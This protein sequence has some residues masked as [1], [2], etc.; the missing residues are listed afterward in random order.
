MRHRIYRDK[1]TA[2]ARDIPVRARATSTVPVGVQKF[3]RRRQDGNVLASRRPFGVSRPPPRYCRRSVEI[4]GTSNT[5]PPALPL[6]VTTARAVLPHGCRFA[7]SFPPQELVQSSEPDRTSRRSALSI[8]HVSEIA[9]DREPILVR[10]SDLTSK[11]V[12]R[13]SKSPRELPIDGGSR[14]RTAPSMLPHFA[15]GLHDHSR[16]LPGSADLAC[17]QSGAGARWSTVGRTGVPSLVLGNVTRPLR[18]E[19]RAP[20]SS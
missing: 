19:I 15:L 13:L 8:P 10:R 7:T 17:F 9:L 14:E 12:G 4:T 18:D 1:T 16:R 20:T 3:D 6:P 5:R 11:P 2:Y